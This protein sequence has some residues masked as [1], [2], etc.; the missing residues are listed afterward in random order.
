M[1]VRVVVVNVYFALCYLLSQAD[2][3]AYEEHTED[4]TAILMRQGVVLR[5]SDGGAKCISLS[6]TVRRLRSH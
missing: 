6:I 3:D 1:H 2:G 5:T 4:V